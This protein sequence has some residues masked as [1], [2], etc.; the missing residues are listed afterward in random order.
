MLVKGIIKSK[1]E[2]SN[3]FK[4]R[5]PLFEVAGS[6]KEYIL[7]ATLVTIPGLYSSYLPGDVVYVSFENDDISKPVIIG[8]LSLQGLEE[9]EKRSYAGVNSL[10]VATEAKLPVNTTIGDI[11]QEK[12]AEAIRKIDNLEHLINQ[13]SEN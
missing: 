8:I 9:P 10:E 2:N 4:V 7:D 12:L 5:L 3:K 11:K 13:E 6:V 1:I